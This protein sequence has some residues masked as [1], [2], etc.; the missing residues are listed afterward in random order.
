MTSPRETTWIPVIAIS[1]LCLFIVL[2]GI[3]KESE[4]RQTFH[5]SA[6]HQIVHLAEE[7][8]DV[9]G[10]HL[11][12]EEAPQSGWNIRVN[13][14]H[15][16]F[17]DPQALPKYIAGQGYVQLS[18]NGENIAKLYDQLYHVASLP[19]GTHQVRATLH[20]S[21]DSLLAYDNEIIASEEFL[22]VPW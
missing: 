3:F 2:T 5:G 14:E 6:E 8:K 21:D 17:A 16:A 19:S 18:I 11:S 10:V 15:F 13:T 4:Q 12:I 9:P 22:T 1:S 20:A 7:Y